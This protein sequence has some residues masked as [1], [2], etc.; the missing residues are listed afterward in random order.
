VEPVAARALAAVRREVGRR[1]AA[2]DEDAALAM[3]RVAAALEAEPAD[4][5]L[6]ARAERRRRPLDEPEEGEPPLGAR[7]ERERRAAAAHRAL[8][9]LLLAGELV[10]DG[11]AAVRLPGFGRSTWRAIALLRRGAAGA[12]ARWAAALAA[13]PAADLGEAAPPFLRG[14][15]PDPALA[16][17]VARVHALEAVRQDARNALLTAT[18]SMGAAIEA[19]SEAGAR[20]LRREC[21]ELE[22]GIGELD[23]AIAAAWDEGV[24]LAGAGSA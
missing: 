1:A 15:A 17:V 8:G 13:E 21:D 7:A 22:A 16:R 5:A 11:P 2:G 9:E 12:P 10:P 6:L 14:L 24:R 20:S 18:A 3:D 23:A 19:G 4:R